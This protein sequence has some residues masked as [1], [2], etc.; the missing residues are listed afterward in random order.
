MSEVFEFDCV[1][2][3]RI[4]L[5]QVEVSNLVIAG[6]TGRDREAM[7][8]H[9]AGLEA[10]GVTRPAKTPIF[11]R[12]AVSLL[13]MDES[14]QV[15][16]TSSSGEVEFFVLKLDDGLWIGLGSDHTDRS[17]ETFD[18]ATSKQICAKPIG[19]TL[20]RLDE[21]AEH[22]DRLM[23]GSSILEDGEMVDYQSGTVAAMRPPR[24]LIDRYASDN[25]G[26]AVGT[27]MFCGTLAAIGGI[28]PSN[29]F[30][31]RL[32]DP[33]LQREITLSYAVS[34]LPPEQ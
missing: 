3:G 18:I 11:Y 2:E 31:A 8:K 26:F 6:W 13:T 24:E 5:R 21:V 17:V 33:V 29:V 9:I 4:T 32:A 22:W 7:E 12:G 10:L 34:P 28:R 14:L 15:L 20:W 19:A 23:L 25:D 27:L 16:G 1:A 30:Q